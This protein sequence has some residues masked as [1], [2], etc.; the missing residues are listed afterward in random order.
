MIKYIWIAPD[1]KTPCA[2]EAF[3]GTF[4]EF[5]SNSTNRGVVRIG[6]APTVLPAATQLFSFVP[7]GSCLVPNCTTPVEMVFVIDEQSDLSAKDFANIKTF[8]KGII[9]KAYNPASQLGWI[10]GGGGPPSNGFDLTQVGKR[11]KNEK[12]GK[13]WLIL[14]LFLSAQSSSCWK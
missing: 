12:K 1:G 10:W 3:D 13:T 6:A 8:L 4:Y 14:I 5:F 2:A 11:G 9:N 7:P